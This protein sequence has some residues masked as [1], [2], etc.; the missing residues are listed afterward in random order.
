MLIAPRTHTG[1][2]Q[3]RARTRHTNEHMVSRVV[4]TCV[5]ANGST[6]TG[7]IMTWSGRTMEY[8][9]TVL[10]YSSNICTTVHSCA[11]YY[12]SIY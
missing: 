2:V 4:I 6:Q 9:Y 8:L 7:R 12:L 1:A 11:L 3:N 10:W 5:S